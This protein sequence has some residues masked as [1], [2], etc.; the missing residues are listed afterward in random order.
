MKSKKIL[1]IVLVVI[2]LVLLGVTGIAFAY[3]KTDFLKTDEQLFYKYLGKSVTQI[4]K[5]GEEKTLSDYFDRLETSPYENN[6]KL[7]VKVEVP[8]EENSNII[9]KVNNT[10]ITFSGKTDRKNQETE[11]R[12]QVNY[13]D[14]ISFPI[15]YKHVGNMYGLSSDLVVKKYISVDTDRLDTLLAKFNMSEEEIDEI[16]SIMD[17]TSMI[18]KQKLED[19]IKKYE[20]I[21]LKNINKDNFSKLDNSFILTLNEEQTLTIVKEILNAL[22]MNEALPEETLQGIDSLL[23]SLENIEPTQEELLKIIVNKEGTINITISSEEELIITIAPTISGLNIKFDIEEGNI[24][25]QISKVKNENSIEYN[26]SIQL[27]PK[28]ESQLV[29]IDFDAKFNNLETQ[30]P[31]ENY[32]LASIMDSEEES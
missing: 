16:L 21:F 9:E 15:N 25:I 26:S 7:S 17:N 18:N 8:D 28:E 22:S 1:I 20:E 23:E 32:V 13:T 27:N 14:D 12:I 30:N 31:Q 10:N 3:L 24:T 2:L 6:G 5:L 4:S 19:E 11:Q 29:E